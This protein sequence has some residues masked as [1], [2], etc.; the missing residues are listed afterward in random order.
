MKTVKGVT[1]SY[2]QPWMPYASV[3]TADME[4]DE[5]DERLSFTLPNGSLV[6]LSYE[7]LR[8]MVVSIEARRVAD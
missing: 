4:H 1:A 3:F 5:A 7:E 8:D 2:R 6:Y